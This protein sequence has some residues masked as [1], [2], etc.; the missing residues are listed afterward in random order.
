[1][2]STMDGEGD[3]DD[4]IM[5]IA[6][7]LGVAGHMDKV[8]SEAEAT[9]R[10]ARIKAWVLLGHIRPRNRQR[11]RLQHRTPP[12]GST[13]PLHQA[14]PFSDL[15]K[16]LLST[17]TLESEHRPR[18]IQNRFWFRSKHLLKGL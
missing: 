18:I 9:I 13:G 1:M 4:S 12:A 11:R 3:K 10:T 7:G 6:E 17:L 14:Q 2:V 5:V 15:L 16:G 8:V